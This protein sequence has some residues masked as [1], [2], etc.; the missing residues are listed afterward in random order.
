MMKLS[1]GSSL[2]GT[3]FNLVNS[4]MGAGILGLPFVFAETGIILNTLLLIIVAVLSDL[5]VWMLI[6][7]L[8]ATRE[9]SFA[10]TAEILYG[11]GLGLLI[12][13]IIFSNNIGVMISYVIV[14]GDLMPPFLSYIG[15]PL[16]FH[17]RTNVV[18][19]MSLPL[20]LVS[21]LKNLDALRHVSLVCIIMILVFVVSLVAMGT[22]FVPTV[23]VTDEPVKLWADS[24]THVM[25]QLPVL[26][27]AFRCQQNVPILYTELRRQ[28]AEATDSKFATKR[29]KMMAASHMGTLV[30]G[31]LYTVAAVAGSA[32]FRQRTAHDVLM[33]F[34]RHI[35]APAPYIRGCYVMVIVC[36]YPVMAFSA[37][38]SFHRLACHI[39]EVWSG[40]KGDTDTYLKLEGAPPVHDEL[41]SDLFQ[42]S[43]LL[44]GEKHLQSPSAYPS[45]ERKTVQAPGDVV[46]ICEIVGMVAFTIWAGLIIPDITLIFGLTGGV[47]ASTVMYVFPSMMYIKVKKDEGNVANGNNEPSIGLAYCVCLFGCIVCV[48]STGLILFHM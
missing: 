27:F 23:E 42:G 33:N 11:K 5:T 28:K 29:S 21:S 12:D 39:V 32:A 9:R 46:R 24:F 15:M 44:P 2:R 17:D 47:C 41:K 43:Y 48:G 36:S 14:I 10:G 34:D 1:E 38:L 3:V 19:M 6:Y 25:R 37:V 30:S 40:E 31:V 16:I 18:L 45:I 26:V 13:F 22:G 20:L 8:D 35:F 4:I 7:C